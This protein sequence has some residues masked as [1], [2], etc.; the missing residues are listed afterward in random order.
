MAHLAE[1]HDLW[2]PFL[3]VS[4][5]STLPNWQQEIARF[6]PG[7]KVLPYWGDP[8]DRKVLRSFLN[9]K[10]LGVKSSPFHVAITS[11]QLI[12]TDWKYFARCS[13]QYM[14]LDEAQAI[15]S[16]SSLRWKSLLKLPSRNRLLL[17]GTPIQ[18]SMQELWSLLHF[19]MPTLFDSHEEFSDWFSKDIESHVGGESEG[20]NE[21]QLRR[22]HMILKP[23][24]LR[25][26]KRDVENELAEKIEI[27]V[28]CSLTCRQKTLYQRLKGK[29]SFGELMSGV[30]NDRSFTGSE[31]ESDTLMNIV[32]QFRKV[33]NHP[34]LFERA[35]VGSPFYGVEP[36]SVG[37]Y[38]GQWNILG[39]SGKGMIR[40]RIPRILWQEGIAKPK[41]LRWPGGRI[42]SPS[43]VWQESVDV[44]GM[45]N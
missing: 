15:K 18:N 32:M 16:S 1:T 11:Y 45:V 7:L 12:V 31:E 13:W 2:G 29:I 3:V 37:T 35:A 33:C 27:E 6:T 30:S 24:M 44:K 38:S 34:E 26:V 28:P 4:P 40:Y 21:E 23:F 39:D 42:L 36:E 22:L 9:P 41:G 5:A 8:D 25:R 17:T 19:I 14:I 43:W 20:L 10:K